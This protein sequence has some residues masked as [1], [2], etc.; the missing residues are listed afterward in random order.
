M[1]QLVKRWWWLQPAC[2]APSRWRW[3][4]RLWGFRAM[5]RARRVLANHNQEGPIGFPGSQVKKYLKKNVISH[6]DTEEE[7]QP[8][9]PVDLGWQSKIGNSFFW[10]RSKTGKFFFKFWLF[11]RW[12]LFLNPTNQRLGGGKYLKCSHPPREDAIGETSWL[13]REEICQKGTTHRSATQD[14]HCSSSSPSTT[15]HIDLKHRRSV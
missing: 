11:S 3:P 7:G 2:L 10:L 6:L 9:S 5:L 13:W 12:K 4:G 15:K 14:V 1:T 8:I